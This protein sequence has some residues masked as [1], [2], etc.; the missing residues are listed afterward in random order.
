MLDRGGCMRKLLLLLPFFLIAFGAYTLDTDALAQADLL[1]EDDQPVQAV[2]VL[3]T[4]LATATNSTDQ[5][6]V[7]WRL[8]RATLDVG[9]QLEDADAEVDEVL[10]VYE[11]GEQYGIEAVAADPDNH[12]AYYWQSANAGRWGQAKG[13]L[14]AL[15]KASPMRDLLGEAITREPTHAGSYYVLG[16]LYA[17]VPGVISFGNDDYAVSLARKSIDLHEAELAAGVEDELFHDYYIQLASHLMQRNWNQ[18]R[19]DREHS[20]KSR[21]FRDTDDRLEQG[22]YYEGTIDI[23]SMSDREEAEE[24]LRDMR[25]RLES[26]TDRSD[27]QKRQLADTIELLAEL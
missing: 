22:W 9:A 15:F 3:E 6:E 11:Q 16:Q 12:L 19:R 26:I 21:R 13:I 23:R 27:G 17:E 1:Y 8:A 20:T 25:R 24:I 5:A 14:D 18:R 7:L 2:A 10:E 4:V